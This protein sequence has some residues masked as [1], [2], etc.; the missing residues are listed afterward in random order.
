MRVAEQREG[1]VA[2]APE[3]RERVGRET[4]RLAHGL[5]VRARDAVDV[6]PQPPVTGPGHR[7][8]RGPER[9]PRLGQPEPVVEVGERVQ[10]YRRPVPP[11]LDLAAQL[12]WQPGRLVGVAR[13]DVAIGTVP[14]S[15]HA[16]VLVQVLHNKTAFQVSR[17]TRKAG[18]RHAILDF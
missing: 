4:R 14:R 15:F 17:R 8:V 1:R 12:E 18:P 9:D 6:P 10:L 16:R 2:R 7:N 5:D 13:D 11:S 3:D